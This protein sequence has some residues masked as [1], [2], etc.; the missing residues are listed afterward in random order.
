MFLNSAQLSAAVRAR[1]EMR[2][3]MRSITP[4]RRMAY[5]APHMS[6]LG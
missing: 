3:A 5:P 6:L 2:I 4:E 1:I